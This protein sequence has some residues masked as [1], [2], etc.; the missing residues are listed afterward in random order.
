METIEIK[1]PEL[2]KIPM[3][4]WLEITLYT[5]LQKREIATLTNKHIWITA[6]KVKIPVQKME[7]SHIKNCIKCFEG[8]G[9]QFIHPNYLGGKEKWLKIFNDELTKR[10]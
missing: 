3:P 10:Q 4:E 2:D 1:T 9:N 7:T 8:T 6:Y 5:P